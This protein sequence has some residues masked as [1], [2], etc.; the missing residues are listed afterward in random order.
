MSD[1]KAAYVQCMQEVVR[2]EGARKDLMLGII[3]SKRQ[4]LA[5]V[6]ALSHM[7]MPPLPEAH[8]AESG[9]VRASVSHAGGSAFNPGISSPEANRQSDPTSA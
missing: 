2:L 4:Q 9:E 7:S 1:E 5:A 3:D 6:C 8:P